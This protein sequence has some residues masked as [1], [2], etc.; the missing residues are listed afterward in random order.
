M[1]R[2]CPAFGSS[3]QLIVGPEGSIAAMVAATVVPLAAD[4]P[5]R[6]AA[7]ASLRSFQGARFTLR[8]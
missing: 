5:R 8:G 4:D 2:P 1:I 6:A 7:L 3:R